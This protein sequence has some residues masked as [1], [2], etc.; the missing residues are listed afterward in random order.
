MDVPAYAELH[1][2]S[3]FSL[4]EGASS[5][6]ALVMEGKRLGLSALALTDHH[7]LAGSV[8]F[9]RAAQR[10]GL[11]PLFGA[12]V[13]L[14]TGDP[15]TLLAETQAGYGN[16]CR[17]VSAARLDHLP[18]SEEDPWPGKVP[19]RSS[20]ERLAE[21]SAGLIALTGGGAN[22]REALRPL[23]DIFGA[24]QLF[25]EL[26][27]HGLPGDDRRRAKW[28]H[29]ADAADIPVVATGNAYYAGA[30]ESRLRDA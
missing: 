30:A 29:L 16:L 27:S 12:E 1:C 11:H 3:Y 19:P 21:Y 4:L 24:G 22:R 17:L 5:P 6:E 9:W 26:V 20:L 2:H 10:Q 15:L 8:R 23:R 18:E 13:T 28:R 25:I 14:E 7:S